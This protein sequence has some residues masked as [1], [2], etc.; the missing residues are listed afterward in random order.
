MGA[1]NTRCPAVKSADILPDLR[2]LARN[3]AAENV[4][5][6]HAGQS[7]AHPHIEMIERARLHSHQHLIFARLRIGNVFIHQ[8]FGSAELMNAD[9]FHVH[10][11]PVKVTLTQSLQIRTSVV[12]TSVHRLLRLTRPC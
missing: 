3:I 9:G 7:L 5:Q 2:N 4:R 8:D 12:A 6:F 1:T 10:F 11:L